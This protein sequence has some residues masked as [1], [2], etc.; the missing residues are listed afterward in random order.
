MILRYIYGGRLSL[1]EYDTSD[2]IKILVASMEDSNEILGGYN[3]IMWTS[4]IIWG[5]TK[6]SFIFSFKNKENIGNYILSRV[7]NENYAIENDSSLGP[8]FGDGDL[9]LNGK[10]H[11]KACYYSRVYEKQ[12]RETEDNFSVEEYEIFQIIKD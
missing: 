8:T 7:K 12:I 11:N 6:D 3:P 10:N 1:E 5:V 2:I 4:N 9:E